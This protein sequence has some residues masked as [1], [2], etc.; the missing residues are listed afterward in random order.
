MNCLINRQQAA[1]FP[2][3]ESQTNPQ[4]Q[5]SVLSGLGS[6]VDLRQVDNDVLLFLWQEQWQSDLTQDA[7][8]FFECFTNTNDLQ[9]AMH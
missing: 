9:L 3:Y 7:C 6:E 8:S 4:A 5:A 1:L 2:L